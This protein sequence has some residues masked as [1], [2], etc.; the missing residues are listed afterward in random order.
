[1]GKSPPWALQPPPLHP[2]RVARR[3]IAALLRRA[4]VWLGILARRVRSAEHAHMQAGYVEFHAEAGAPEG[5]LFV[6]G[7]RVGTLT[8]VTRL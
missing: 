1:M 6:D 2:G 4:S 8:G 5:A 7:Q 3:L